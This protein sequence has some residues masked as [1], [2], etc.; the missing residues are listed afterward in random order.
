MTPE[1]IE[2]S[3]THVSSHIDSILKKHIEDEDAKFYRLEKQLS[4]L[5][6]TM[7]AF[8]EAWQQA[9]GVITFVKWLASIAGG[10]T[11]FVIFLKDHWK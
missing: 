2:Q 1:D 6:K 8:V 5:T 7:N 9:K 4:E 11:A 3:V 10:L